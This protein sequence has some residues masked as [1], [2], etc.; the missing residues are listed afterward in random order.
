MKPSRDLRP[1]SSRADANCCK[2]MIFLIFVA[3]CLSLL[4]LFVV[5]PILFA[6]CEAL[7]TNNL[8]QS[9]LFVGRVWHTRFQPKRH[10][11]TYPIFTFA[12]DLE[13]VVGNF[14]YPIL[15]FRESD[16]LKNGEGS[17]STS[18]ENSLAQRVL[19]LVSEKTKGKCQPSL[20]TDQVF[21]LTHVSC[22]SISAYRLV[23][24]EK[25]SNQHS[26]F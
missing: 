25:N 17:S 14:F 10:A 7:K 11:F 26:F 23:K 16:H 15:S 24:L 1:I 18:T 12:L 20:K 22:T 2:K 13:E 4:L 3:M 5:L 19:R 9:R 8:Q 6:V 21:L